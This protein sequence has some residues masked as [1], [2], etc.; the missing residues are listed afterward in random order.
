[1]A[2]EKCHSPCDIASAGIGRISIAPLPGT[3]MEV[4]EVQYP[5]PPQWLETIAIGIVDD[6]VSITGYSLCEV[7]EELRE[8]PYYRPLL[9]MERLS[10]AYWKYH[11]LDIGDI[12][13]DRVMRELIKQYCK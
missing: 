8:N 4:I 9:S 3:P 2:N 1:L 11:Q 7:D 12:F 5:L 6:T 13:S 10:L